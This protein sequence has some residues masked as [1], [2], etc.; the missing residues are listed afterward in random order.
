[1]VLKG[2][3]DRCLP[4][5][6][7]TTNLGDCHS[8]VMTYERCLLQWSS[9]GCEQ[10]GCGACPAPGVSSFVRS[11]TPARISLSVQLLASHAQCAFA[12]G[13]AIV[14]CLAN[15]DLSHGPPSVPRRFDSGHSKPVAWTDGTVTKQCASRLQLRP[16]RCR[17]ERAANSGSS[18][19]P[20][21]CPER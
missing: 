17:L 16:S 15:R 5:Q 3:T 13:M 12:P 14:G 10:R 21:S 18:S 4:R 11:C 1:M 9:S 7:S 20:C 8:P 2:Q 19:C 6:S